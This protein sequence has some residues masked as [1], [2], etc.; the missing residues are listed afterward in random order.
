MERAIALQERLQSQPAKAPAYP[1][2]LAQR[3]VEV[4][5]RVAAGKSDREI[6]EELSIGVRTVTSQVSNILNTYYAISRIDK[7]SIRNGLTRLACL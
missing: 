2:G 5:R 1:D 7:V 4:L 6:T 3:E